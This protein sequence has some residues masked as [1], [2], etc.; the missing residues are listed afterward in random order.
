MIR[1]IIGLIIV[2]SLAQC[3]SEEWDLDIS[4]EKAQALLIDV[5]VAQEILKKYPASQKD[6][7]KQVLRA[8]IAQIQNISEEQIDYYI[9]SM[10]RYTSD[11]FVIEENATKY[12]KQLKD[13]MKNLNKAESK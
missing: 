8:N 10:Q 9:E 3:K 5:K 7:M 12:F 4:K 1:I 2:M 11:Y 6:S 13:S